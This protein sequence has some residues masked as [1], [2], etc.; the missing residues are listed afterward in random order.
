MKKILSVVAAAVIAFSFNACQPKNG[1][2]SNNFKIEVSNITAIGADI[3][4]T[5]ADT[6]AYYSAEIYF[7]KD[8]QGLTADSLAADLKAEADAAK[9]Q[10][11]DLTFADFVEY[12]WAYQGVK[13]LPASGLPA[14]SDY[15]VVVYQIDTAFNLVGNWTR[16]N[17]STKKLEVTETINVNEA[18]EYMDLTA[19]GYPVFV[20]IPVGTAGAYLEFAFTDELP[21]G[22]FTEEAFDSYYGAWYIVDEATEEAYP[23][24]TAAL[25]GTLADTQYT[26]EGEAVSGNGIKFVIKSVCEEKSM[27]GG[28]PAKKAARKP[29][30][31]KAI[32]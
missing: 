7:T 11:P 30:N 26:L 27:V 21:A 31:R 14:E 16:A 6:L 12:G 9:K 5:P 1:A 8:L 15:T 17:F 29:L 20:D 10:Y 2:D 24:A 32:R 18:G 3:K 23:I 13:E 22:Q 4:V 28:A 19:A 25:T